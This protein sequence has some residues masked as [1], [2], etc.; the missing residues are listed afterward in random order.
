MYFTCPPF[1]QTFFVVSCPYPL[2]RVS[3]SLL[4]AGY[5]KFSVISNIKVRTH[6]VL[7]YWQ[8]AII[9]DCHALMEMYL[10]LHDDG[11]YEIEFII[12]SR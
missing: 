8:E 11:F 5:L 9:G 1:D 10:V 3:F 2:K 6:K 4:R 12:T 7:M